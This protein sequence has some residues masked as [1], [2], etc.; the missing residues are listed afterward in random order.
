M[1]LPNR[2]PLLDAI[3]NLQFPTGYLFHDIFAQLMNQGT[4]LGTDHRR[5][6]PLSQFQSINS[7]IQRVRILLYL[8]L[9]MLTEK[10]VKPAVDYFKSITIS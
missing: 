10:C 6:Q 1:R 9:E 8:H 5:D 2:V 3:Q 7:W 4:G